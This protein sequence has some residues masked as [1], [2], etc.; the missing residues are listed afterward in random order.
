MGAKSDEICLLPLET[1]KTAFF[2]EILK[3]VA[4]FQYP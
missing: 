3:F 4:L 1:K 2:A